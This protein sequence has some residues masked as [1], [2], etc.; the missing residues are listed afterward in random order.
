MMNPMTT[1]SAMALIVEV[2]PIPALSNNTTPTY[3]FNSD[4]TGSIIY[5]GSCSA[6]TNIAIVWDNDI[7]FDPFSDGTYSNCSITVDDGLGISNELTLTPFTIDTTPPVVTL[8]G[9]GTISIFSGSSFSDSGATWTDNVDGS[10]TIATYN[11]GTLNT[12]QTGT[13]ILEYVQV[14]AA[15][16]TGST[17]RT[18][19]VVEPPMGPD[20]TPPVVTLIGSGTVNILLNSVYSDSGATWTDAVDGSGTIAT[21]NSGTLNTAQTGSYLLE[22]VQVDAAGN[23]GSTTRTVNVVE[24]D[25]TL[26]I[27]SLVGNANVS[28][29]LGG[30]YSDLGATWTDNVDGSGSIVANGTVN[31]NIAW[32][33]ILVYNYTDTS[34]NVGVFQRRFVN[35]VA[36]TPPPIIGAGGGGG[37]SSYGMPTYTQN[38]SKQIPLNSASS[39]KKSLNYLNTTTSILGNYRSKLYKTLVELRIKKFPNSQ[40]SIKRKQFFSS[41]DSSMSMSQ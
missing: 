34:G 5:S 11:S 35:V 28:I 27:I 14:D 17:T 29:P 12:T 20:T 15:G 19:N 40:Y 4:S 24:P 39:P 22:Y 2:V 26:P 32:L 10:G 21:Y 8:V 6:V 16:N 13:Y 18:V 23:T 30:A 33:Y 36:P 38:S 25:T 9:S 37:G 41:D 3:V 31:T 7:T 1:V